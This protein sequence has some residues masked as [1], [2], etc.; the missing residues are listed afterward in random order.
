MKKIKVLNV[1]DSVF[2]RRLLKDTLEKDPEIGEIV[3]AKNGKEALDILYKDDFDC[4]TLDIEMPVLNGIDTLKEIMKNKPTPVVMIS[5]AT[6]K[7]A[8]ITLDALEIGAVDFIS[9]PKNI[10]SLD[11][12]ELA[13]IVNTVKSAAVSNTGMLVKKTR[14]SIPEKKLQTSE[15]KIKVKIEEEKNVKK[16]E[17]HI[18][19]SEKSDKVNVKKIIVIGT[20]TGGPRALQNV[21]PMISANIRAPIL[22]VQ[23]MPEGFT[24]S[25]ADRLNGLSYIN[26]KE[27]E[28]GETI[29][30]GTCYVAPGGKHLK[31]KS[32][33]ISKYKIYLDDS[34]VYNGHRPSVDVLFNSV[35]DA[36][37]DDIIAV[38]MTGMGADGAKGL[39]NL[40][41]RKNAITIAEDE[42]TC[43]VYG[44]PKSAVE[45]GKVDKVV[46]LNKIAI[47]LNK[48]M[49]V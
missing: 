9:K 28:D 39:E 23:H 25:L 3:Q 4:I 32:V 27:A 8:K 6:Q 42:S 14:I 20:S 17:R 2:M 37:V 18:G 5:T 47:E 46:P 13:I 24:K 26:V 49:G 1:D 10:F 38:I 33:G 31:I 35:A 7:Y 48:L 22:V 19:Y 12:Q 29:E 21:I 34:E 16:Y 36:P 40:K 30:N 41:I 45:T 43:V 15:V 44:M 11:S